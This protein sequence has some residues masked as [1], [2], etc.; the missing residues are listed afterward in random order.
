M[1]AFLNKLQDILEQE[2]ILT[3]EP[4]K[5]HT[6]FK[7]GGPADV[8]VKPDSVEQIK[9]IMEAARE[10]QIPVYI[11][12]SRKQ[13]ARK[14]RGRYRTRT[15]RRHLLQQNRTGNSSHPCCMQPGWKVISV[16][17]LFPQTY[18][19]AGQDC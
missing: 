11:M 10:E 14:S 4:M 8:F 2:E 13:S 1:E 16:R 18:V 17:R 15:C 3:Q 19:P 5:L 9:Q 7:V 6:T 12:G